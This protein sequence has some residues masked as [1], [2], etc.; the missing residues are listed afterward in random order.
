MVK[1]KDSKGQW[2]GGKGSIQKEHDHK[3]YVDNWE[4]I[5]GKKKDDKNKPKSS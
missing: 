1:Q 3:K 2:H 5:F 4:K